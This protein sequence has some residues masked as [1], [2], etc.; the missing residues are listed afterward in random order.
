[1][2]DQF[3]AAPLT[4]HLVPYLPAPLANLTDTLVQSGDALNEYVDS[5]AIQAWGIAEAWI[6]GGAF[7]YKSFV[8]GFALAVYLFETYLDYRQ[9]RKLKEKQRPEGIASIVSQ[10]DFAKANAYGLDKSRFSFVQSF[11]SQAQ[12]LLFLS[13]DVLP[14]LWATVGSCLESYAGLGPEYEI[15]QS[16]VFFIITSVASTVLSLPFNIFYTFVIEERHGFN[17]QTLQMFF[18][19]TVK[20]LLVGAVIGLPTI[21]GFLRITQWAGPHFY[22][23]VWG[24]VVALQIT[25]VTIYPTIIQPLFNK[26]TP[27]EPGQ[28]RSQ[29]EALAARVHF[30]LTKLYVIDGSKRSA[31]S[32]AYF[33]GFFKNKRIVLYDTLLD[34]TDSEEICAILGHELGHWQMNH[35]I[36]LFFITQLHMF[37]LFYL[38]SLTVHN[39]AMFASFGFLSDAAT[40]S[41]GNPT[42]LLIGF[43]L[44]QYLY[45]P[46]ENVMSFLMNILSRHNEFEADA[47]AFHLGYT[48]PLSSAL[49]K[50]Q[51]KNLGN[52]N[53]DPWYSAY[54]YSHPPLV[55]R[56]HALES[57]A[58]QVDKKTS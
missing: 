3:F 56:L 21:A 39:Q 24:F 46:V 31:H 28:L 15:T 2:Y 27:L 12:S 57:L 52:M 9:H 4:T 55:E 11:V 13:F 25:L 8:I 29:I 35:T 45:M 30:P 54:H 37:S 26:L 7:P 49:I 6:Y 14:W 50:L 18:A 43:M 51:L 32:N 58:A 48:Q 40:A 47:Y 1:M 10:D 23:Y 44:F 34:H 42:P 53:P 33:Y 5:L 22:V 16:L 41:V 17:K 38:F 19:D 36:K 20:E